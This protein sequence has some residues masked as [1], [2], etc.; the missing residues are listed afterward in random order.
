MN[1]FLLNIREMETQVNANLTN[2]KKYL[3]AE[4]TKPT[5]FDKDSLDAFLSQGNKSTPVSRKV[6]LLNNSNASNSKK[7]KATPKSHMSTPFKTPFSQQTTLKLESSPW[8]PGMDSNSTFTESFTNRSKKMSVL[9]EF[10]T[11]IPL[12]KHELNEVG[13][14]VNICL[15]PGQLMKEYRYMYN[16][17]ADEGMSVDESIDAVAELIAAQEASQQPEWDDESSPDLIL[18]HQKDVNSLL[19]KWIHPCNIPRQEPFLTVGRICIDSVLENSKLN[20]QSILLESSRLIG[21]GSRIQLNL[22]SLLQDSYSLFPGQIVGIKGNNPSGR[23]INV[24]EIVSPPLPPLATSSVSRLLELYSPTNSESNKPMETVIAS[25]PFTLLDSLEYEPWKEFLVELSNSV[26]PQVLIL[27]G[28]FVDQSHPLLSMSHR[29]PQELF[30]ICVLDPLI[31]LVKE[32]PSFQVIL[33][34]STNDLISDWPL[35][36]QPPLDSKEWKASD[37]ILFLPNPVSFLMN[38]CLV[39]IS[40]TDTLL[41]MASSESGRETQGTFDRI[42]LMYRHV[43]QQRH[44]HPVSPTMNKIHYEHIDPFVLGVRP[45]ILILPSVLKPSVKH[46]EGVMC[47]NPGK[48]CKG[49][50]SGTF[51]K[52]IIYPLNMQELV[53]LN[54][55]EELHHDVGLRSRTGIYKL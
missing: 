12:Y 29:D 11:H 37:R 41:E 22:D 36:P 35:L 32:N 9:E 46:V 21:N 18:E 45:D 5:M 48:L 30:Q 20:A 42:S 49:K 50:V 14:K 27:L 38:E 17:L 40:N 31:S 51:C 26:L 53:S 54:P 33:I 15:A 6:V 39:S 3:S 34:P 8:T 52:M 23:L 25:G 13:V 19:K 16:K 4:T 24:H 47:V 28:P 43:L 55:Q 44:L 1:E 7:N 2:D 10:N